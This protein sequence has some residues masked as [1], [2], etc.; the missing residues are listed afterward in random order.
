MVV[1]NS[2]VHSCI[3]IMVS[4]INTLN[5]ATFADEQLTD[6]IKHLAQDSTTDPKVKRKLVAVLTAW[7]RQFEGDP[8]MSLVANLYRA[9]PAHRERPVSFQ[10]NNEALEAE[11]EAERRRREEKEAKEEAK[12]K[13]KQLKQEEKQRRENEAKRKVEDKN[14]RRF[15]FDFEKERPQIFNAIA[16]ASQ[17]TTNLINALTVSLCAVSRRRMS[18]YR[19]SACEHGTRQCQRKSTR[20]RLPRNLQTMSKAYCAIYSGRLQ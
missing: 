15:P 5:I 18:T 13:A 11:R 19:V 20:T 12:R 2:K 9:I 14:R 16:E 10:Q 8:K 6:A 7:H 4:I 17:A 1:P 3:K